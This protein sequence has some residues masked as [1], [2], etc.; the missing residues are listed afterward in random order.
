MS[1]QA[2]CEGDSQYRHPKRKDRLPTV[3]MLVNRR[4]TI[5][6]RRRPNINAGV[7]QA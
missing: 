3:E 7:E 4:E 2:E 6:R 1:F 5:N